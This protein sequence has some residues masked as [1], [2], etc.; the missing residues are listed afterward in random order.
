MMTE[1]FKNFIITL[2]DEDYDV[3]KCIWDAKKH[4]I[5]TVKDAARHQMSFD[6]YGGINAEMTGIEAL[7]SYLLD[8]YLSDAIWYMN[9]DTVQDLMD[10]LGYDYKTAKKV[11]NSI[12]KVYYKC[13]KFIGSENDIISLYEA[14]ED[15]LNN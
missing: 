11:Y 15:A 6:I 4:W 5:C 7:G 1:H 10:E 13:R 9:C 2:S 8:S 3:S 12:E 14:L